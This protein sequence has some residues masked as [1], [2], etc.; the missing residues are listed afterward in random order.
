MAIIDELIAI[1][2][3]EVTGESE[4]KQYNKSLDALEKKVENV[5]RRIG[6]AAAIAGAAVAAGFAFLGKGVLD[7]SA[8]FESYQATL[9]TIEGSA[10]KAKASL[11]W[12]SQFAKTTPYEVDE[13]TQAFVKLRAYGMDPMDGTLT[14]LGDTASGMG[15]NLMQAVEALADA[16][17]GEFER[18]KEFGVKAKVSGD[19]VT[20]AWVDNGKQMT[21]TVKK[22]GVEI[23][24]TL[25]EIWGKRF[26]GAMIRQSKTWN[27]MMSNLGD[28]WTAFLRKIGDAGVFEKVKN[29]LGNLM[30]SINGWADDGTVD[31][32]AR[33]FSNVFEG[34][35]NTLNAFAK[36]IAF[37]VALIGRNFET[38]KPYLQAVGIALG[39]LMA[40]AFPVTTAFVALALAVDDVIS[41]LTGGES[42][43]GDF[44]NWL[45]QL[46]AVVAQNEAIKALGDI[47]R[48][49]VNYFTDAATFAA[50]FF[51]ALTGW[52]SGTATE[53]FRML[54]QVLGGVVTLFKDLVGVLFRLLEWALPDDF[55][56]ADAFETGRRAAQTLIDALNYLLGLPARL[57]EAFQNMNLN[58]AIPALP[59]GLSSGP[60]TANPF[61]TGRNAGLNIG[62]LAGSGGAVSRDA[63]RTVNSNVN[64]GGVNVTVQSPTQAPAAVGAAVG[65][66]VGQAATPQAT[67]IEAEPSF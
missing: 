45:N 18:I 6:Q 49:L 13:I 9:E 7:T 17:T 40:A 38:L 61:E 14:A 60:P 62:R 15:K 31:R 33:F 48:D 51:T 55:F 52:D 29:V 20:F 24:K 5:G 34:V 47:I 56:G 65:R 39:V 8:K 36:R 44:I 12:V 59:G 21:K 3:Y 27:G 22:T 30:D 63:N 57:T 16:A 43:I 11:D 53:A 67:R 26:S 50:G 46:W 58:F 1:L 4:L 19:D 41:Y 37:Y 2:G 25:K 10:E 54:G 42:V 32:I 35:V 23:T 28:S 64:V 66:A